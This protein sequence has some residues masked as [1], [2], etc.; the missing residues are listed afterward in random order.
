MLPSQ[1]LK[2]V[3]LLQLSSREIIPIE[4][5]SSLGIV[6]VSDAYQIELSRR[7]DLQVVDV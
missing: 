5:E 3:E 2:A 4:S 6:D 1:R 7:T